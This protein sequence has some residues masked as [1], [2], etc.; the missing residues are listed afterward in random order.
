MGERSFY[1]LINDSKPTLVDFYATWCGPCK[2]MNPILK[3]LAGDIDGKA[4]ILKVDVDKNQSLSQNLGIRGVPTI[5]VYKS[6]KI[7]WR[8]S[9]V[10]T[11]DQLK[12]VLFSHMDEEE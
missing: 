6:G 4:R 8:E 2:M 12:K 9:G 3:D 1:D 10:K 5:V 7:V 11:K